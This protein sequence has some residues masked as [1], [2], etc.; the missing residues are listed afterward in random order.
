MTVNN[1]NV[2]FRTKANSCGC[3]C[4]TNTT[5]SSTY[6]SAYT[7]SGCAGS[8]SNNQMKVA[9]YNVAYAKVH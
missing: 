8:C 7:N 4:T 3:I 1:Y 5:Y 9:N 2:G 6:A